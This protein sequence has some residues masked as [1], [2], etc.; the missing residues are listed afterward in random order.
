MKSNERKVFDSIHEFIYLD[1][2]IWHFIDTPLFQRLRNIKQNGCSNWVFPG[3][4]HSRL[5][6]CIG[7]AHLAK[8][9]MESIV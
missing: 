8:K 5:E 1:K 2:L 9:T 6:H 4:S 3:V 7:T